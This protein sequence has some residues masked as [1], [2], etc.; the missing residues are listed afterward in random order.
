MIGC[1]RDLVAAKGV[2]GTTNI[3]YPRF[4]GG[5]KAEPL[6]EPFKP[7]LFGF[8]F[9]TKRFRV[10]DVA[11]VLVQGTRENVQI[12]RS[13]S[14]SPF[15]DEFDLWGIGVL[16]VSHWDEADEGIDSRQ[17]ARVISI[18][19]TPEHVVGH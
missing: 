15:V 11:I 17:V 12:P 13:E 9:F 2:Q 1:G 18:P 5:P 16:W 4:V 6:P 8:L 19:Y 3:T 10:T 14:P 7:L